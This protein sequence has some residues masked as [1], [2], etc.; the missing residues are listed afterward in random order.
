MKIRQFD[1][2]MPEQIRPGQD[3][4]MKHPTTLNPK[5]EANLP[6]YCFQASQDYLKIII[7]SLQEVWVCLSNKEVSS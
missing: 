6:F 2:E 7:E 4:E 5:G 1:L 3:Q